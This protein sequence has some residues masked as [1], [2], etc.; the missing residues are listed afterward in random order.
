MGGYKE[1]DELK[2]IIDKKK[3]IYIQTTKIER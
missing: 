1:Y 3:I 2:N